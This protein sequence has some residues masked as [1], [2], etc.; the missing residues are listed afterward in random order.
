MHNY[1]P[2]IEEEA[3]LSFLFIK[4]LLN[5]LTQSVSQLVQRRDRRE[6]LFLKTILEL[7][8][9]LYSRRESYTANTKTTGLAARS[10]RVVF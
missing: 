8:G 7:L 9:T 3:T 1:P 6:K 2:E 5:Q 4:A 10:I